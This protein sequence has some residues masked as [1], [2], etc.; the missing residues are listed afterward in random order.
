MAR[1]K[2][3]IEDRSERP[4]MEESFIQGNNYQC[5]TNSESQEQYLHTQSDF[6]ALSR[7]GPTP[8]N[9]E[10]TKIVKAA[11]PILASVIINLG[12]FN[13]RLLDTR[14]RKRQ[15]LVI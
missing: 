6:P 14:T 9:N 3:Q 2:E 8:L 4:A 13:N 10:V 11:R 12:D 5:N 7:D 15:Q 1:N